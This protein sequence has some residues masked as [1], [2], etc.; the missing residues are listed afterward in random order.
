MLFNTFR[1][2][3]IKACLRSDDGLT[4]PR[5]RTPDQFLLVAVITN[6]VARVI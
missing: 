1:S 5:I 4:A 2:V 3:I 6:D